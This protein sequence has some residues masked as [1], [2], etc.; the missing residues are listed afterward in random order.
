[1][2]RRPSRRV[3]KCQESHPEGCERSGG[4]LGGSGGVGRHSRRARRGWEALPERRWVAEAIPECR[5]GKARQAL[6]EGQEGRKAL[7][8]I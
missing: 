1:M 3:S 2:V 5:A 7:P 8:E 4:P 6:L